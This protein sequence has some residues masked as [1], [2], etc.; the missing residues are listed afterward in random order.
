MKAKA[1]VLSTHTALTLERVK[2][3]LEKRGFK[4]LILADVAALRQ[5]LESELPATASVGIGGSVTVREL[6]IDQF[7]K[8]RGNPLLDHWQPDLP[9]G[10]LMA[11]R[12]GQL[13]CD[14]F[15]TSTNALTES[16]QLVNM[17]GMGNRVGAMIFGP[18]RVIVICGAN[19]IVAGLDEANERI[20]TIAAPQN[21]MRLDL[22]TPCAKTGTCQHCGGDVSICRVWTV[23]EHP[24]TATPYTVILMPQSL[25]Y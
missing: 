3:N 12:R 8:Q 11:V 10:E 23:I 2:K 13:T 24:P 5:H 18:K 9:K 22:P 20:R 4:A 7:L 21:A 25:G 19:K 15:L 16:G 6:G 1:D 14:C 17:D